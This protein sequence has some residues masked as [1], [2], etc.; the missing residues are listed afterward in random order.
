M[1]R[2]ST[3]GSDILTHLS[4]SS[5]ANHVIQKVVTTCSPEMLQFVVDAFIG[6]VYTFA[7]HPYSCRVLQR[8]LENCPEKMK[9]PLL[10]ELKSYA[11][12]LY[13]E[14]QLAGEAHSH[15]YSALTNFIAAARPLPEC[16]INMATMLYS[17]VSIEASIKISL[18]LLY[19]F[20]DKSYTFPNTNL[21]RMVSS[22]L[23]IVRTALF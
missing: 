11:Q 16:K 8:M 14:S 9:R 2:R 22:L 13:V 15:L 18:I 12:N 17:I 1:Y 6:S 20:M 23:R 21:P 10:E 4:F 7:T 5:D 3:A 19:R